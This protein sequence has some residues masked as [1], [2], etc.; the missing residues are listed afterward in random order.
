MRTIKQDLDLLIQIR[1]EAVDRLCPDFADG[2]DM[3]QLTAYIK[4]IFENQN[5][6]LISDKIS[7]ERKGMSPGGEEIIVLPPTEKQIGYATRLGIPLKEI[8]A[9][10]SRQELSDLI[11]LK[12]GKEQRK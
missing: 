2:N 9:C 3:E 1:H 11:D 7:S 6:W 12:V 4:L 8:E 10:R 5:K